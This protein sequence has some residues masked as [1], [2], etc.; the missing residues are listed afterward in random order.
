M[1]RENHHFYQEIHLQMLGFLLSV[2][3]GVT[4]L[5]AKKTY[6]VSLPT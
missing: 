1:T 3:R 2:F 6:P 4:E 5:V